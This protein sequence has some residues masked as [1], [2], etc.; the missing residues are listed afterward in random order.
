MHVALL[1]A[2]EP[3]FRVRCP[4]C[5][6]VLVFDDVSF[7]GLPILIDAHCPRCGRPFL[8]DWPAG[9]ALLHQT[10]IDLDA[11]TVHYDGARW[12]PEVLTGV[13]ESRDAP[14]RPGLSV[15]GGE[16]RS[17]TAVLVNCVD[18]VFG[19]CVLKLLS[20]LSLLE[21]P[22]VDV[23]VVVQKQVA[24][25]VPA[26]VHTVVEVGDPRVN[27]VGDPLGDARGWIDGLD[28]T[29]KELLARY[30]RVRIAPTPSQPHVDVDDLGRTAPGFSPDP[31]WH[32]D[33]R[34]PQVTFVLR[35]DRLWARRP[36]LPSGRSLLPRPLRRRNALRS[37]NRAVARVVR[38]VRAAVPEVKF[39]AVG[40]GRHGR[41]PREVRDLR[42]PAITP[43]D[44]LARCS[45]FARSRLVI[46]VHGSHML[47]PSALAGGVIDLLPPRKL[48]NI[49]QD[50]IIAGREEVQPK[51]ALFRYRILP[52]DTS[53]TN[54][55]ETAVSI[56]R[57]ADRYY[58]N[59]AR[60]PAASGQGWADG[61]E[62]TTNG[63]NRAAISEL[64]PVRS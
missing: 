4:R 26:E 21:E 38:Q 29:L 3:R 55:S 64:T 5:D 51:L 12:Y 45:E 40:L 37:Q 16:P 53:P 33:V 62:W 50:L 10:L 32:H 23:I 44:E 34:E 56:L 20:S 8:L 18:Y 13:L 30:E 52:V 36:L 42:L 43:R 48:P 57:D 25:L 27:P 15:R 1:A 49:A 35:E 46:G 24:W 14:R 7:P 6:D 39:V 19:H 59:M 60:N 63:R 54:V 9:H 61:A 2:L 47:L 28:A 31:F 58:L 11:Q 22:G 17:S 41:L